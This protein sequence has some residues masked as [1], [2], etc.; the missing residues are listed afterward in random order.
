VKRS[1]MPPRK[2]PL[3]SFTRLRPMSKRRRR[4]LRQR[5]QVRVEVL[6]RDGGCVA[7]DR[8]PQVSCS[9]GDLDVHELVRRSQW[10]AGWLY[11]SNC[12]A[13][14]RRH[15]DYVGLHPEHA[16]AVGLVRWSYEVAE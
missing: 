13:I 16:H 3:R 8:L 5:A 6:E 2:V 15:H 1:A 7:R 9:G 11:A 10:R 12:V 4:E 14:C